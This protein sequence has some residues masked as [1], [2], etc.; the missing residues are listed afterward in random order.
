MQQA[1]RAACQQEIMTFNDSVG[2]VKQSV[3]SSLGTIVFIRG[4]FPEKSLNNVHL[5]FRAEGERDIAYMVKQLSKEATGDAKRMYDYI[6]NGICDAIE[7]QYL[8]SFVFAIYLD[9]DDPQNIVEAYTFNFSYREVP[10][11]AG[12]VP[13]MDLSM[14]VEDTS[15]EPGSGQ[16]QA[17]QASTAPMGRSSLEVAMN[18]RKLLRTISTSTSVMDCLPRKRYA[19]FKLYY[20]PETPEEYEPP[21]FAAVDPEEARLY[22][23]THHSEEVPD[24]EVYGGIE[25]AYHSVDIKVAS[26]SS[27]IPPTDLEA[28]VDKATRTAEIAEQ[29]EDALDRNVVWSAE[30]DVQALKDAKKADQVDPIVD[31]SVDVR[32]IGTRAQ[33]GQV[34]LQ[35]GGGLRTYIG[36]PS[37]R[38]ADIQAFNDEEYTQDVVETQPIEPEYSRPT[39]PVGQ[40]TLQMDTLQLA[41][42][43]VQNLA[44]LDDTEMLYADTQMPLVQNHAPLEQVSMDVDGAPLPRS[45]TPPGKPNIQPSSKTLRSESIPRTAPPPPCSC[46]GKVGAMLQ[47]LLFTSQDPLQ[48]NKKE[49]EIVCGTCYGVFHVCCMGYLGLDD[50]RLPK[51]FDC[52]KCRLDKCPR[53]GFLSDDRRVEVENNWHALCLFRRALKITK[54]GAVLQTAVALSKRLDCPNKLGQQMKKRL[55]DE[56]FIAPETIEMVDVFEESAPAKGKK[57]AKKPAKGNRGKLVMVWSEEN[58]RKFMRYFKPGG[59][60]ERAIYNFSAG[61]GGVQNQRPNA[62]IGVRTFMFI[63]W[64]LPGL[65]LFASLRS[66]PS[67]DQNQPE[68]LATPKASRKSAKTFTSAKVAHSS[69]QPLLDRQETAPDSLPNNR[70][71]AAPRSPLKRPPALEDSMFAPPLSARKRSRSAGKTITY[72]SRKKLKMSMATG[73]LDMEE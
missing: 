25:T 30:V 37:A 14:R 32:P 15:Q 56:G 21:G 23:A 54:D 48:S 10:G 39:T 70:S 18:L 47:V 42:C 59:T 13:T 1:V 17:K 61:G 45:T 69:R 16:Q 33:D 20:T 62:I 2:Y 38:P 40:A 41:D 55:E 7:K 58:K 49:P 8:S 67:Q 65:I 26:L 71:D 22:F 68:A 50:S 53:V 12:R 43:V 6:E 35:E 4:L 29:R 57:K 72:A 27:Y 9:R 31:S 19:T 28:T 36:A 46:G 66:L 73:D 11:Q 60:F 3:R 64:H 63:I 24:R 44:C 52:F 51:S 34:K 5:M